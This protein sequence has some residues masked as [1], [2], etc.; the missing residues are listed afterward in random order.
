MTSKEF[1]EIG[2]CGG[3]VIFHVKTDGE[4][5]RS[6]QI[7]ITH[8]A[9]RPAAFFAVW[10]LREGIAVADIDV[11]GIG[12]PWNPPPW[13][14]CFPVFIACDAQGMYGHHCPECKQYWRSR[15]GAA[16]CPYCGVQ[17]NRFQF[18][19]EAQQRY[20][21]GYC[22]KLLDALQ[23]E[24]DGDHIIDMD[25]VADAAGTE[26]EKPPFYY[27][28]ESQQNKYTCAACG[29]EH[30]IL[31]KFGYCANCGTRNDVQELEKKLAALRDRITA[32]GPYENYVRDAVAAFDSFAGQYARQLKDRVPLIPERRARL[33]R[34]FHNLDTAIDVFSTLF[35]ISIADGVPSEDLVFAKL[36]FHRRHVYEHRGGEADE[37]YI[38]DSGDVGVRPKQAL[39][40]S[41]D[42][43]HRTLNVV[44]RLA[45]NLHAGFHKIF[46]PLE[47]PIRWHKQRTARSR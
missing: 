18:L 43:A 7:K 36:M 22:D 5:H 3:K 8:S 25:A 23:D 32:G 21:K 24:K 46:E 4:G 41:A 37:K 38:A 19:T 13:P 44:L 10:A 26:T 9:P 16:I 29:E 40:E 39:Q 11:G 35:G 28:E 2:H 17:A 14:G 34:N 30:D 27:A 45:K 1:Q 33:E 31:G 42:S 20:V 12:H 6:Y 47:E 15:G